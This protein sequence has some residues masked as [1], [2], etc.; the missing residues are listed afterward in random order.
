MPFDRFFKLAL[1]A[2]LLSFVFVWWNVGK[3]GRYVYHPNNGHD[4][5]WII[6]TRTA[7][8]FLIGY[9]ENEVTF[10]E[11]HPQTGERIPHPMWERPI[12]L[13]R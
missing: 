2:V 12:G 10:I 8:I 5:S 11:I 13:Q 7:T 9:K 6:D 3:N 4:L 1:L